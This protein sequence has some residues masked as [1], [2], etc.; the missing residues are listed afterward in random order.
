MPQKL[1]KYISST[2]FPRYNYRVAHLN[3]HA[4]T[5]FPLTSNSN[6]M[7]FSWMQYSDN[8]LIC[9]TS[10]KLNTKQFLHF[11]KYPKFTKRQV[12]VTLKKLAA[13]LCI[14]SKLKIISEISHES[15]F[16]IFCKHTTL[17]Q[18]S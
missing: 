9:F 7:N 8:H 1:P 12:T 2:K 16:L 6:P 11:F 4:L 13:S 5:H 14:K 10:V 3:E 17:V 18:I 15:S